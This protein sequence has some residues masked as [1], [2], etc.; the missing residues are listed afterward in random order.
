VAV[1]QFDLAIAPKYDT[2]TSRVTVSGYNNNYFNRFDR[3][4][5]RYDATSTLAIA[6]PDHFGDHLIRV[7]GQF[8]HTTYNG[9]DASSP[10][11]VTR[12]DGS[13]LRQI[14]YAGSSSVG[15]DNTDIAGSSRISGRSISS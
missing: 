10:V 1:K 3:D 12:A 6:A 13:T 4:S 5:R 14:D 8:S 2:A 7:G 9:I 11:I 15:A